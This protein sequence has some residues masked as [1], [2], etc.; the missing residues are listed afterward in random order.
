M[1]RL[2]LPRCTRLSPRFSERGCFLAA[3]FPSPRLWTRGHAGFSGWGPWGQQLG[4]RGSVATGPVESSWTGDASCGP[5]IG[6]RILNP[7]ITSEVCPGFLR[8][9]YRHK[10]LL[11]CERTRFCSNRQLDLETPTFMII[12]LQYFNN[13]LSC[14]GLR[15]VRITRKWRESISQMLSSVL[16]FMLRYFKAHFTITDTF[17]VERWQQKGA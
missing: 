6:G 13:F 16:R 15:A 7:W 8:G 10:T 9:F 14:S 4:H 17:D 11:A 5:C 12:K 1:A 2:G 3:S